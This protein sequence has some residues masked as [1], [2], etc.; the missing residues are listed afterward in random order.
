MYRHGFRRPYPVPYLPYAGYPY[1][2][3]I[4]VPVPLARRRTA[5]GEWSDEDEDLL[6]DLRDAQRDLTREEYGL[7]GVDDSVR[8]LGEYAMD[9]ANS[10]YYV[11]LQP[12]GTPYVRVTGGDPHLRPPRVLTEDSVFDNPPPFQRRDIPAYAGWRTP[13]MRLTRGVVLQ[14]PL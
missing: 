13:T 12:T 5:D 8:G 11:K 14:Y 6:E 7:A 9:S 3:P 2:F 10:G 1:P 4:P